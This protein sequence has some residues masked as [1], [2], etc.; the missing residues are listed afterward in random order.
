MECGLGER[1]Y[2]RRWIGARHLELHHAGVGEPD[3][4]RR[5][6]GREAHRVLEHLHRP[7]DT[8]AFERFERR[9]PFD[10]RTVRREQCIEPRIAFTRR[11]PCHGRRKAVPP[12][13]H[14]LDVRDAAGI[15][16]EQPAQVRNH[17]LETVI[18]D[19]D[20]LPPG[21]D[22]IVFGDDL[23]SAYHEHAQ[24]IELPVGNRDRLPGRGQA[25][26][27]RIKLEGLESETRTSR[28]E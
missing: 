24:N 19:G 11:R 3:M 5:M 8:I 10:K 21:L 23:A 26:S 2:V 20:I 7:H 27:S 6:V 14:R 18:A 22:Q 9:P 25:P 16:A 4:G 17:L 28:H 12:P 1:C 13:R 15:G